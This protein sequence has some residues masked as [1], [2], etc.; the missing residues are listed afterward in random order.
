[1]MQRTILVLAGFT[2]AGCYAEPPTGSLSKRARPAPTSRENV[3]ERDEDLEASGHEGHEGHET[4]DQGKAEDDARP[5]PDAGPGGVIDAF[6][7][8][9]PY[10]SGAPAH[11][12]NAH[13]ATSMT[14]RAC[15]ACHSSSGGAPV[16]LF[17]GTLY[18]GTQP[19]PN[20]QVRVTDSIGK[21]QGAVFSDADGNFWLRRSGALSSALTGARNASSKSLMKASFSSGDCN[22]STCHGP[23]NR[24]DLP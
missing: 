2:L 11:A 20:A 13:H 18:R 6:T 3:A 22:S 5:A 15:L 7:G 19:A 4:H 8:A 14:G 9:D 23:N 21:L 1:M 10:V 16:F 24:I 17:A 12:A